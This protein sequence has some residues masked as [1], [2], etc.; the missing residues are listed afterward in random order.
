MNAPLVLQQRLDL[1]AAAP[2][3]SALRAQAGSDL[4]IDAGEVSHLGGLCL[5][6][7]AAAAISWRQ[8]GNDLRLTPRSQ[9][10]DDALDLFGVTLADLETEG[11]A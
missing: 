4:I 9:S 6:V 11:S 3:A 10:F 7:L 2:L 1:P 8:A 5:Q